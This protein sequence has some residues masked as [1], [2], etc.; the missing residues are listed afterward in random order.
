MPE[1][2]FYMI[3]GIN[4]LMHPGGNEDND[5]NS[6]GSA[7]LFRVM[8]RYAFSFFWRQG[9]RIEHWDEDTRASVRAELVKRWLESPWTRPFRR[10][11]GH[12]TLDTRRWMGGT[13]EIGNILGVN[14]LERCTTPP[15]A[16][17][18]IPEAHEINPRVPGTSSSTGLR[19]TSQTHLPST[20]AQFP[21]GPSSSSSLPED[22]GEISDNVSSSNSDPLPRSSAPIEQHPPRGD[23]LKPIL[24]Q[25]AG[26]GQQGNTVRHASLLDT[27]RKIPLRPHGVIDGGD[28]EGPPPDDGQTDEVPV[29]PDAVLARSGSQLNESSAGAT[30]AEPPQEAQSDD[31]VLRDRML[32]RVSYSKSESL[33]VPFDEIQNR[34]TSH[35]HHEG[36][37]EFLVVWRN[38]RLEIYEDY[39]IPGKEH[40]IGHKNLAFLV[41]L[42][43]ERTFLSLY[44]FADLTFCILCP[45]T[46][47]DGYSKARALFHRSK[48]GTNVFVFKVKSRTRAQ[49]WVWHL[50]CHLGGNIPSSIEIRCPDISARVRIDIPVVN[51]IN[52]DNAYDMFSRKNVVDLVQ[53]SLLSD[54][55]GPSEAALRNWRYIIEREL[56]AG[57]RLALAW[58]LEA[59]LD[60]VW[61]EEDVEGN[62]RPWAV[63]SGLALRQGEKASHLELRLAEHFPNCTYPPN[64]KKM[65]EPPAIEGY[66]DRIKPQGK[67]RQRVYLVTHGG[68]LFSLSPLDA[69]PPAPPSVHLLRMISGELASIEQY[70]KDIFE[71]E[72][73]RG[74][75]QIRAAYGVMDLR[76]ISTDDG[77]VVKRDIVDEE[78]QGGPE[79]L[80]RVRDKIQLRLR[81]SFEIILATGPVYSCRD[82]IEWVTRLRA[83]VTY[84]SQR[85]RTDAK[86]EMDVAYVASD[87]VRVTPQLSKCRNTNGHLTPAEQPRDPDSSLPV[88]TTLYH[89]CA[90]ENCRSVVKAGRVFTRKGLRGQYKHVQLFLVSGRLIGFDVSPK[91]ILHHRRSK[92][93]SLLDAYVC[94]GYLATLAL[95]RSE[96]GPGAPNWPRRY[97]DG[98]ETDEPEEDV[99][100]IIWHRKSSSSSQLSV[101]ASTG[102]SSTAPIPDLSA[103]HKITVFRTRSKVER[104]AWCWALGCEM[105]KVVRINRDRERRIR[106]VGGLV[107][108]S[109]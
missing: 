31:V 102:A 89:W 24:K 58:R 42:K 72:V 8:D 51:T 92:E 76:N 32:V 59:Q 53:N 65:L 21:Q 91:S 27:K 28:P 62:A 1:R 93:I 79:G 46:L 109:N 38:D 80:A 84:W 82:C 90:L 52:L 64:G 61:K 75:V 11:N 108:F 70:A 9:G 88:L 41:P 86:D 39:T 13:F 105:D 106:E 23:S 37:A 35:L 81:R 26:A 2:M 98:L 22:S 5:E 56:Q 97:Y 34:Q 107:E 74:V 36:W 20:S 67:G 96:Y 7:A 30:E 12:R 68:N 44:S 57:G 55:H 63:L 49:D 25:N 95:R 47:V 18:P 33:P 6:E 83:L 40:F 4:E 10:V 87:R 71:N 78:D 101:K 29:P 60:W 94:S 100:F 14:I 73:E 77:D 50:W 103:S 43:S 54:R 3:Q 16:P 66:L 69:T 48:E 19:R 45:P 15:P 104:D 99:L 85:Y 17:S